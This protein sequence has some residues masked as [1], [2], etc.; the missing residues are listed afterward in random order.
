MD[1]NSDIIVT[2]IKMQTID[3]KLLNSLQ[4]ILKMRKKYA[5]MYFDNTLLDSLQNKIPPTTKQE[6]IL[7]SI[8]YC[9]DIIK[10]ILFIPK[11]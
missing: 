6:I 2:N 10:D 9:N 5:D 1:F 7:Q 8:N 11:K 4:E 3:E